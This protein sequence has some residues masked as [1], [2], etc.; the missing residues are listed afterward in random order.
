MRPPM[1]GFFA[2]ILVEAGCGSF[3]PVGLQDG[4]FCLPP[5]TTLPP[6]PLPPPPLSPPPVM[7]EVLTVDCLAGVVFPAMGGAVALAF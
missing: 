5:L 6:P 7:F 1:L 4:V 2:S 3:Q